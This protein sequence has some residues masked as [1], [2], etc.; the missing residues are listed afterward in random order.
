MRIEH[1]ALWCRDLEAMRQFYCELF[2]AT[3]SER[4]HNPRTGFYSYLLSFP[5]GGA[6]LELM[7]MPG[8]LPHDLTPDQQRYGQAHFSVCVENKAAVAQMGEK[9]TLLGGIVIRGPRTT[10]DGYYEIEAFDP[11]GNRFEVMEAV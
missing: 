8:L 4:Y 2:S 5:G 6:R 9:L 7:D 1:L 3:A 10:G 11:E